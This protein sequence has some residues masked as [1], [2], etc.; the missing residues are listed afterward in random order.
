[1]F[2]KPETL[3]DT[4]DEHMIGIQL[5]YNRFKLKMVHSNLEAIL[6]EEERR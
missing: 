4:Q 3:K 5:A 6:L 2:N 1:M